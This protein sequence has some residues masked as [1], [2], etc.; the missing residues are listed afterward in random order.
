LTGNSTIPNIF[1][2]YVDGS[3]STVNDAGNGLLTNPQT[4]GD[5][6]GSATGTMYVDDGTGFGYGWT[7]DLYAAPL[8][9]VAHATSLPT[10]F[11]LGSVTAGGTSL[12]VAGEDP[13]DV[14]VQYTSGNPLLLPPTPA[15]EPVISATGSAM[16]IYVIP[17]N[18]TWTVP[19]YAYNGTYTTTIW[20]LACE[21]LAP[22]G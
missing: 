6:T 19:A 8:T 14:T 1:A 15:N 20:L 11:Y 17:E 18:L 10:A 22:A 21:N 3:G 4:Y 12:D 5:T 16:G 13:G 7:V 2:S 9:N